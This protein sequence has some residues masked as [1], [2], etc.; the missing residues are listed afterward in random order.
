MQQRLT[1]VD[2]IR[3]GEKVPTGEKDRNGNPK[4]RP[5]KLMTFRLTSPKRGLMEKVA[6]LYGGEVR[7]W[8]DGPDGP[9]FQVITK[10]TELP[11]Y[12][13]PQRIDPNLELWG[14]RHRQRLCDGATERIRNAPCLCEVAARRRYE[15][16]RRP[17][18][19]DGKFERTR[20][21]CKPTTR[22]SVVLSDVSD[23]QWKLESHGWNAAAELPTATTV[24]LA[25]AQ[26]PVPA[27]LKLDI[28]DEPKLVIKDGREKVE[29]RKFAVPVLDFG[30]LF[31]ARQ[32]LTG[33]ID[34]AV[35]R[36]LAG[37]QQRREI[38]SAP[39]EQKPVEQP[40]EQKRTA[41]QVLAMV[42]LTRN[43]AQLND[44]TGAAQAVDAA[45]PDIESLKS[46]FRRR[47]EQFKAA[48]TQ[49]AEPA[50]A[51]ATEQPLVEEV[52]DA[53]IVD[54]S[55]EGQRL[56]NA[57]MEASPFDS[58]TELNRN[59]REVTGATHNLDDA[60]VDEL[61]EYLKAL[62]ARAAA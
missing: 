5:T 4:F 57:V 16:A 41:L 37:G 61:A 31:N 48:E 50:T 28:R 14:N 20:D 3:L 45:D 29:S 25:M 38:G 58:M 42:K 53:E 33:G 10:A 55:A 60:K 18:P 27:M 13:L 62:Q 15:Q 56:W 39:A 59:F 43:L 26:K 47:W 24:Y 49:Q 30:D 46:E 22:L 12:V 54:D 9:E 21:D 7:D 32:A 44:L 19:E 34:A 51:T 35:E 1:Q 36:A 6:E 17:W 8:P 52:V 11:V 2:V 40:A 23:G